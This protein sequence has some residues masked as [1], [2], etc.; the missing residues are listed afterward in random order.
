MFNQDP[1]TTTA[2]IV[3]AF[4]R[5]TTDLE[6]A[7]EGYGSLQL[8]LVTIFLALEQSSPK[9]DNNWENWEAYEQE[10]T[11]ILERFLMAEV[12]WPSLTGNEFET[13]REGAKVGSY[14]ADAMMRIG[15]ALKSWLGANRNEMLLP[16]MEYSW[17]DVPQELITSTNRPL[18]LDTA[19][20]L[21]WRFRLLDTFRRR[22]VVAP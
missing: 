19:V 16:S 15:L 11:E 2:E 3:Q 18:R 20:G 4:R 9:E 7:G 13:V 6:V 22:S 5:W 8:E 1:D 17:L 21:E 14:P 10:G 12:E